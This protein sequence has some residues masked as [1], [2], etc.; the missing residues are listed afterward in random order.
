MFLQATRPL[1]QRI[2]KSGPGYV[3]KP[4]PNEM[5]DAP[6]PEPNPGNRKQHFGPARSMEKIQNKDQRYFDMRETT[7]H[8]RYVDAEMAKDYS[9][10]PN[11]YGPTRE[12]IVGPNKKNAISGYVGGL[13]TH[14]DRDISAKVAQDAK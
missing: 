4:K 7:M 2:W 11:R 10:L 14:E 6:I 5:L 9:H 12:D 3:T 1:R 13:E 8:S